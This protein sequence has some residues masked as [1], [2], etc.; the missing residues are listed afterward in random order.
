MDFD[1]NGPGRS[2]MSDVL[3]GI[4]IELRTDEQPRTDDDALVL[5]GLREPTAL[6]QTLSQH[7]RDRA[8][9]IAMIRPSAATEPSDLLITCFDGLLAQLDEEADSSPFDHVLLTLLRRQCS[10]QPE[11]YSGWLLRALVNAAIARLY[12]GETEVALSLLDEAVGLG[13]PPAELCEVNQDL[14]EALAE[15]STGIKEGDER[16]KRVQDWLLVN[17]H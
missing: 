9:P 6:S 2:V 4:P 17:T 15:A 7:F 1:P 5:V 11:R 13:A 3:A 14:V 10:F 16:L 12:E 8:R